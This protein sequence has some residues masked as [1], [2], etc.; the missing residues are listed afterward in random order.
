M[1]QVS[2]STVSRSLNDSPLIPE[3]TRARIRRIAEKS[4]FEFN[5]HA[6]S[7]ATNRVGTIGLILPP[8]YDRFCV[9]LYHGTLHNSLRDVLERND[10][11]LLVT[12]LHNRFTGRDNVRKLTTRKKID[13]LI[14]VQ[15]AAD[16]EL[17]RFLRGAGM[18]F[19]FT[20]FPPPSGFPSDIDI[21]YP[22]NEHGGMLA[23]H[24]FADLG[25]GRPLV[26]SPGE[27]QG[28]EYQLR[29]AGFRRGLAEA[30]IRA[31]PLDLAAGDLTME[32]GYKAVRKMG[33]RVARHDALFA[34]NDLLAIGAVEALREMGRRV[35]EDVAV[36][37]YDDTDL[38]AEIRPPLTTIHQ[39]REELSL[40]TC[41]RLLERIMQRRA[42]GAPAKGGRT[43]LRPRIVIRETG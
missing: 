10:L 18:P 9:N 25:R 37:G 34:L 31:K 7:L 13:G 27:G 43:A 6:R 39:P 3:H 8:D 22:D 35:P 23:A 40:A 26:M 20:H 41:T 17:I 1:A 32:S 12:F 19:V 36:I 16:R 11:D 38:A 30:G 21:L 33:D 28:P 15:P 42:G 5:A 2:V 4:G 14:V 29:R 24:R